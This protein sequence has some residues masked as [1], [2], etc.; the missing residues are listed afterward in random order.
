MSD[1]VR[2]YRWQPTRLPPPWDFPGKSTGV[3]C[4]CL[5]HRGCWNPPR[6]DIPTSKSKKKPQWD[7][8]RGSIMIKS[9]PISAR[10]VIHKL[11]NHNT[12]EF[13]PLLWRLWTPLQ[14]SQPCDL[15]KGLGICWEFGLE[16]QWDLIIGLTQDWGNR[17]S[18]LGGH[19]QNL[20]H[21]K[22]QSKGAASP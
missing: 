12:K 7:G 11:E 4:H 21:T 9:N 19:K 6:K 22:T 15:T 3:G 5:L 8:R 2:P 20:L 14:A 16:G 17:D 1:S 18:S 10:C 13:L